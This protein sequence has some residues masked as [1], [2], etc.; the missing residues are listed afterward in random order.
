M[1]VHI[2][3]NVPTDLVADVRALLDDDSVTNVTWLQGASIKP[4]GDLL[5]ADVAREAAST[6]LDE[7]NKLGLDE[8]GG[9]VLDQPLG[10]PF[11]AAKA[12]EEHAAGDADDAVIWRL[13]RL[14]AISNS[15]VT[16]SFIAL[17][18]I[19]TA[20]A[21]IAVLTD[22]SVLVVGAMVVGP[23]FAVVAAACVGVALG[24]WKLAFKSL[25]TLLWTFALAIAVIAAISYLGSRIGFF[26][27]GQVTAPRPQTQF[28]WRPDKW[29][30]VVA[31]WAGA[32]GVL[33]IATDKASAMVGVFISVTTVPAAGNVA[34]GLA[35][36][37]WSEITGSFA[38]LGANLAGMLI[39]GV[40]TLL[41]Q[42]VVWSKLSAD[43]R[44]RMTNR[45]P[46]PHL[47]H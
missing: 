3:L 24:D 46:A 27:A 39:S 8:V 43:R 20:L 29:S 14:Q 25:W 37:S 45:I 22:S 4:T 13:V 2:R 19:A 17:L 30:I 32:A 1:L 23:E 41:V 7:L 15:K 10:T 47:H 40:V 16:A 6:L 34:L 38:Q 35:I 18:I 26:D 36:G 9:I 31:L 33:A 11:H 28:I 44:Q 12:V 42:R 21:S 5:E